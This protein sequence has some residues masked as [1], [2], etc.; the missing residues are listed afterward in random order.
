M[1]T[2][3]MLR[4]LL[5]V[6][7][8]HQKVLKKLAQ[9]APV[10]AAASGYDLAEPVQRALVA[11]FPDMDPEGNFM[12][13]GAGTEHVQLQGV[14]SVRTSSPEAIKAEA[15][16]LMRVQPCCAKAKTIDIKLTAGNAQRPA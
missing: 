1:N 8:D 15:L 13:V 16:K 5:K 10:P 4:T 3:E 2:N 7:Q 12:V 6:A 14:Y 9:G 11:K